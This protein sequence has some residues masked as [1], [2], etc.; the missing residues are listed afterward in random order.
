MSV[1]GAYLGHPLETRIV[2]LP[3]ERSTR[4]SLRR[5]CA[6]DTRVSRCSRRRGPVPSCEHTSTPTSDSSGVMLLRALV[7]YDLAEESTVRS[8][9]T[10]TLPQCPPDLSLVEAMNYFQTGKSHILL[11]S[12]HPGEPRGALGIVTLEDIVEVSQHGRSLAFLLSAFSV[13]SIPLPCGAAEPCGS[14]VCLLLARSCRLAH[15]IALFPSPLPRLRALL[16]PPA[17]LAQAYTLSPMK[18]G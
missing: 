7:G 15:C 17:S 14:T 6:K 8:L 5:S 1:T 10:Q 11:V 2:F 13:S 16:T 12:T 3:T 9:V 4:S 18:Q